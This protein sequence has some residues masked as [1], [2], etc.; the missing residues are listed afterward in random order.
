M[1][2]PDNYFEKTKGLNLAKL[3]PDF[4]ESHDFVI[5]MSNHGKD[6]SN[7]TR[8]AAIRELVD[9]YLAALNSKVGTEKPESLPAGLELPEKLEIETSLSKKMNF[10]GWNSRKQA[11]YQAAS[12][13]RARLERSGIISLHPIDLM[14]GNMKAPT[15]EEKMMEEY[16]LKFPY[17]KAKSQTVKAAKPA[18]SKRKAAPKPATR[19]SSTRKSTP[20]KPATPKQNVELVRDLDIELRL[21]TRFVNL[22]D[23]PKTFQQVL[24]VFNA[25]NRAVK[26]GQIRKTDNPTPYHKEM[27]WIQDKLEKAL[28][29]AYS[30]NDLDEITVLGFDEKKIEELKAIRKKFSVYPSVRLGLRFVGMEGKAPDKDRAQRLLNAITSARNS[31][32]LNR[33]DLNSDYIYKATD[34]LIDYV[35]GKT[36]IISTQQAALSGLA[37]AV[38]GCAC[39]TGTR[40]KKCVNGLVD[41]G[42]EDE[43]IIA[44]HRGEAVRYRSDA[45]PPAHDDTYHFSGPWGELF[46]QPVKGFSALIYGKPKSGKSTLAADLGGYLARSFGTVLYASIE[47]GARGTITERIER[48][49]VGHPHMY[50]SNH[51]PSDL[52]PYDFV[53]TDS[54]SRGRL[55][56]EEMRSLISSFPDTSFIF[57]FHVTK[58]GLPR[59]TA[60][61]QHEVD[62]LVEV[63]DGV[64]TANGRFGPGEMAVRFE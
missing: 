16:H 38:L 32:K 39:N 42:F 28:S 40:Q 27:I 6:W 30:G 9:K 22:H 47:E 44:P 24:G 51:L 20:K 21:I 35:Q 48:L 59:G 34:A 36:P 1:I 17:V 3:H 45:M 58:S 46:G 5:K 18:A 11:I 14:P 15:T 64:A 49:D 26:K 55:D 10:I 54:V 61:F 62:V 41:D 2:T 43:Y 13:E 57:I 37:G 8:S 25:L 4:P 63:S 23:K 50:V 33:D 53:I 56:L 7:Y 12:G 52:S 31:G 60:E 19:K 29:T